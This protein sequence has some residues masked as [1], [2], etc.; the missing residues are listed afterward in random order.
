MSKTLLTR[1]RVKWGSLP[2][3]IKKLLGD[4]MNTGIPKDKTDY[5]LSNIEGRYLCL[6]EYHDEENKFNASYLI[7]G[8][9]VIYSNEG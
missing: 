9:E 3:E 7:Y 4:I 6:A 5:I 2:A 1:K 8:D